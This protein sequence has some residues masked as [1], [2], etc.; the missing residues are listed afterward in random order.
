MLLKPSTLQSALLACIEAL[1]PF[2]VTGKPGI[3]KSTMIQATVASL[4]SFT[5]RFILKHA[6]KALRMMPNGWG[7]LDQRLTTMDPVDL[8]GVPSVNSGSTTWHTPD[9]FPTDEAVEAGKFPEKG[10]L[11]FD[12]ATA[13]GPAM[14]AA[15]YEI[16]LDRRAAGTKL[17]DGW[18]IGA[19]GNGLSDNAVVQRT[20]STIRSRFINLEMEADLDDWCNWALK[21]GMEPSLVAFLRYRP[22]LLHKHAPDSAFPCPR[23]WEFV[24]QLVAQKPSRTVELA[25][26]EGAVGAGAATEYYAFLDLFRKLPSIDAILLSPAK[27]EVPTDPATRY[28]VAY[29]L[30]F[31]AT[32]A[33]LGAVVQ[34]LDRMP[35]EYNVLA[36]KA[37]TQ[38]D[39]ALCSTKDFTDWAVKHAQALS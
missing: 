17:A 10:L 28:A 30:A 5:P 4:P 12:E 13:V 6:H 24:S 8:R 33:N 9:W 32:P 27:H 3:G 7:L 11:F 29:A 26:I 34:Y 18:A 1:R 2:L 19:A 16:L 25:L 39:S 21:N 20:T 31:R 35:M 37:A 38:R 14:Q 22:E 23:T 36:M 15:M